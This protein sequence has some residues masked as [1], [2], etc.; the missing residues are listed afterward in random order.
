MMQHLNVPAAVILTAFVAFGVR[1][2]ALAALARPPR[3]G[4]VLAR[5]LVALCWL[6]LA[7]LYALFGAHVLRSTPAALV[8]AALTALVVLGPLL[9]RRRRESRRSLGLA[10]TVA[11]AKLSGALA[12]LLA[13]ALTLMGAGFLALT[14]DRP[15]LLVDVTGETATQTVRWAPPDQPSREEALSVHHV[16]FRSPDGLPVADAWLYGDE[17]AVKGRVL[18]LA[19]LLSAAGLPNLFELRFAHNGYLTA[20]RHASYPHVAVPLPPSGPLAVHPWWRPLQAW[21]LRGLERGGGSG[22]PWAIRSL[23]VES[24]FFPLVDANGN[25]VRQLYR[26]VLT[27]GGLSASA[28]E[29]PGLLGR[30]RQTFVLIGLNDVR[31]WGSPSDRNRCRL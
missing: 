29:W 24:T 19:P 26:V 11:L 31:P 13:A 28:V 16:I 14:V 25:P 17:V 7:A 1:A 22:Q 18:R 20:E 21:L 10:P 3:I 2:L 4:A 9:V 5:S 12:L 15:V 6:G 30:S 8:A 23:T 27:P